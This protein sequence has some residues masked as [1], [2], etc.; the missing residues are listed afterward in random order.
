MNKGSL[1]AW[2]KLTEQNKQNIFQ[3][4]AVKINLPPAAVEKDWWVVRTT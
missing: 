1:Q 2:L 4:V 3:E